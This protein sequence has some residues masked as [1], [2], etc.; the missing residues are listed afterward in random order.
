MAVA[1]GPTLPS[2]YDNIVI[3]IDGSK[4]DATQLLIDIDPRKRRKIISQVGYVERHRNLYY[5]VNIISLATSVT[6][7]ALTSMCI[8]KSRLPYMDDAT[9]LVIKE[10]AK[11]RTDIIHNLLSMRI[12]YCLVGVTFLGGFFYYFVTSRIG[13]ENVGPFWSLGRGGRGLGGNLAAFALYFQ[14]HV[15]FVLWHFARFPFGLKRRK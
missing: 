14:A 3:L 4:D 2:F 11:T 15:Y 7:V 13:L 1:K 10:R 6:F 9:L 8:T 12:L 5:A